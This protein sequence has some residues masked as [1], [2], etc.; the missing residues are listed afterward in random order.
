[1]VKQHD[2]SISTTP[3]NELFLKGEKDI[4]EFISSQC[5]EKTIIFDPAEYCKVYKQ[6]LKEFIDYYENIFSILTTAIQK[7][8]FEGYKKGFPEF[9]INSNDAEIKKKSE[10]IK[11]EI[12]E[13]II[14]INGIKGDYEVFNKTLHKES[15]YNVKTEELRT[16]YKNLD[17][18]LDYID[19]SSNTH[20]IREIKALKMILRKTGNKFILELCETHNIIDYISQTTQEEYLM[21]TKNEMILFTFKN[22]SKIHDIYLNKKYYSLKE[23]TAVIGNKIIS[24]DIQLDKVKDILEYISTDAVKKYIKKDFEIIDIVKDI[25]KNAVEKIEIKSSLLVL[26]E[27]EN[28]IIFPNV[29]P[30]PN[31]FKSRSL[32]TPADIQKT[33][34]ELKVENKEKILMELSKF[35]KD[36][37]ILTEAYF[38]GTLLVNILKYEVTPQLILYGEAKHG[39]TTLARYF[40]FTEVKTKEPTEPQLFRTCAGYGCGYNLFDEPSRF[41]RTIS[42][43]IKDGATAPEFKQSYGRENETILFKIGHIITCNHP[44]SINFENEDDIKAFLRRC[45][46][47]RINEKTDNIPREI[48][49][50]SLEYLKNNTLELKKIF[51]DYVMSLTHSEVKTKYENTLEREAQ[52]KF[53]RFSLMLLKE[54][55]DS[56]NINVLSYERVE[57]IISRLKDNEKEFETDI[58]NDET[59]MEIIEEIIYNDFMKIATMPDKSPDKAIMPETLNK[60][61]VQLFN[62]NKYTVFHTGN[63]KRIF[64]NQSGLNNLLPKLK[65]KG[66]NYPNKMKLKTF[67]EKIQ[68]KG[69][70]AEIGKTRIGAE[71]NAVK[72]GLKIDI[73]LDHNILKEHPEVLSDIKTI[74]IQNAGNIDTEELLNNHEETKVKDTLKILQTLKIATFENDMYI[75]TNLDQLSDIVESIEKPAPKYTK[76]DQIL[77]T[78]KILYDINDKGLISFDLLM[79]HLKDHE[80]DETR[81]ILTNLKW[82]GE[83]DEPKTGKFR[84]I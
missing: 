16:R 67:L 79:E 74:A 33:L 75:I 59:I 28:K 4:P 82:N 58:I 20:K 39:K 50:N 1:V 23:V 61:S 5:Y 38:M 47:L 15:R 31:I 69:Y 53:I 46:T 72:D 44:Y 41:R 25:I 24:K 49:E 56:N 9:D 54:F 80:P 66:I 73:I 2:T 13:K 65:E 22:I 76:R 30:A 42:D 45:I 36:H 40:N 55:Y 60:Y 77:D 17:E 3:K 21:S 52:F 11:K 68:K 29:E 63:T 43:M 35:D 19:R 18:K 81:K 64:L 12:N 78:L 71:A 10:D 57:N 6:D 37:N 8:I 14:L 62:L 70:N 26:T 48:I 34:K 83:I 84:I 51:I 27:H 32:P 7:G